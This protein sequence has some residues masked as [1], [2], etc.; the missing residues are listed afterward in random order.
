MKKGFLF[1]VIGTFTGIS[2]FSFSGDS[3]SQPSESNTNFLAEQGVFIFVQTYLQN[4]DGNFVTYL[5][6]D[7]FTYLDDDALEH[8]LKTEVSENDPIIDINGQKF[9]VIKRKMT[10]S[11]DKENVI[12][13]TILAT[14]INDS[15][16]HVA[17]FA[18]DGYPIVAGDKIQSIWTFL[19]PLD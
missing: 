10:I 7:K 16:T 14:T 11:Y 15:L 9:Q 6:S 3:Y 2:L 1:L 8:L 19:K 13:S 12:A 5:T 4:S 17:R 18:H